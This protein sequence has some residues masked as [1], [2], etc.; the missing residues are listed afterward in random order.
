MSTLWRHQLLLGLVAV[1]VFFTNLGGYALFDED[2]PKNA[3][4]GREMF[5]R[6]DW[7]VPTFNAQ[8][9]TDKPILIY[10]L[11]QIS[12]R[13]FG[14]SEFA[15]RFGSAFLAVGTTLLT[16]HL[17]RKLYSP[18]IG[19]LAGVIVCTSLMFSAVGRS[20]TP[21]SVLIF[22][23]TLAFTSYVWA[24]AARRGGHFSGVE[25]SR[26]E[27]PW[28]ELLPASRVASLPMYAAMGLA[29]LAKGPIGVLLPCMIIGLLLLVTLRRNDL[30]SGTL[31]PPSG[32]WWRRSL[33]TLVQVMRP[34]RILEASWR[35]RIVLGAAVVL[36]IALPWY[37]AVGL[38][39]DGAWLRGF[40]GDH[41]VGRFLGAKENHSGPIFYYVIALFMGCFPWSVFLPLAVWQLR[42]RL[43]K[44]DSWGD[45][46][47]FVACWAGVWF[48]FF[49]FASTKLPNYVL[50]MYP[51][52]AL[53]SA[54]YLHDWQLAPAG[55]GSV[56]FRHCC[57]ILAVLGVLMMVGIP[58]AMSILLPGE[59]WLLLIGAIP[60]MGAA[61]AFV[62]SQRE[63]RPRAIRIL[64]A[65]AIALAVLMLGIAPTRVGLHQ[66][67]PKLAEAARQA[68]GTSDIELATIDYFSPNLV[69]Y[70][71]HPVQLLVQPDDVAR[72]FAEH[73]R[74]FVVTRS[75]KLK[76]LTKPM[77]QIVEVA[78]HRRFL[79]NHDLVLL[80]RPTDIALHKAPLAR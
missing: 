50:P 71:G 69:F 33:V 79:R 17:G 3:V 65:S 58:I 62:A 59:E 8:L 12:F 10:W 22:C 51:A 80:G 19:L 49:S 38:K 76:R 66:D 47:R 11:M 21:D 63:Q 53:I 15:A 77:P 67:S 64:S 42:T 34:S 13:L 9:R 72:F 45:S 61:L 4:C 74:G 60:L 41:N 24:V 52:L 27:T 1:L 18:E 6:G 46:D 30:T 32:P 26:A 29:I 28:I 37:V 25:T 36:A 48:V 23:L 70:A 31:S 35:M 78:R 54:R 43:V 55:Q 14:V 44:G 56:S 75:D 39:T 57:R 7:I 73:P 68:A 20:V 40:L 2:E 16:Y 5:E